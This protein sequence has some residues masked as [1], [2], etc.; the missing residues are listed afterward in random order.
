[1]LDLLIEDANVLTMDPARPVASR[2]GVWRGRILGLDD[3]VAGLSARRTVR[4]GG[5][6]VLPGFVDAHTHMVWSG[7][8]LGGTDITGLR[9]RGEVL[10][11]LRRACAQVAPG[12]WVEVTGYDQRPI[13]G[14]LTRAELDAV[15]DGRRLWLQHTSGHA[16]VVNSVVLDG[17][18]LAP[19]GA[20]V[21]YDDGEPNGLML[22]RAQIAVR[23][24]RLPYRVSELVAAIERAGQACL[25]QG[26]TTCAEAGIGGGLIATPPVEV[27]A[28]QTARE[29]GRL[30]VRMQLMVAS[31]GLRELAAHADDGITRGIDL[32]LRTGFGD[33]TLGIGALKL[34]LDGGIMARTAALTA[35]YVGSTDAGQLQED[36]AALRQVILDGHTAG[37]QLAVHAIGDRALDLALDAIAE[38][39]AKVPRPDARH[40][41][42]HCGLVRDDQLPRL[43]ELGL[44][45]VLQPE[46]LWDNGDDYSDVLGP[47]RA[48]WLY[49]GRALLDA[50]VAIASSSDRPVVAGA[51]L[52]A[53][54]FMVER[55]SNTGRVV[56]PGEELT[57]AEALA[58]ATIGAARACRREH[59]CGSVEPGKL[60]DFTVLERNPLD[61]PA[62]ELAG[63]GVRA[64][65]L[66]GEAVYGEL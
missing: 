43:A 64:T 13:G 12:D 32:G 37:W 3:D 41:I 39:Q 53:I 54:Q 34:W 28:Y 22:E 23:R 7:M 40:R 4:L 5:A 19:L 56:G 63:T 30:P 11:V 1:M 36:P 18:D 29:T 31:D 15:A 52:R 47:D 50:G 45:A 26:I 48:G 42:E 16:G 10:E 6:T 62:A 24:A 49:R 35:P 20:D 2:I 17:I 66:G 51:P 61:V 25:A 65:V 58:A 44:T 60:A 33:E 46:F 14:H 59:L 9:D 21:G 38:A 27:A 57:V 55:R 8:S